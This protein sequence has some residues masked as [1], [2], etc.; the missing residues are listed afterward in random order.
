MSEPNAVTQLLQAWRGGNAVARDELLT[1]VYDQLRRLA[2][3]HMRAE[4]PGHTLGATA[5]VHEAYVRLVG[6]YIPFADRVHFFAAAATMMRRILVDHSKQRGR[7]KR[8]GNA[9]K[10]SLEEAAFISAEPDA[11]ILEIDEALTR[12]ATID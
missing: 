1:V 11:R 7:N 5:L 2:S 10:L 12:L 4:R 9:P 6:A 3:R 8:G